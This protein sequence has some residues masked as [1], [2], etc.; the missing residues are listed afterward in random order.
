MFGVK[1]QGA[2][3]LHYSERAM[4]W[5]LLLSP[6]MDGPGNM[7]L[8]HALMAHARESGETVLRVY[9]WSSRVLSLGR[10]QRG[11]GVYDSAELARHGVT[12]VRRPTGGRALLHHREIT[13][14]VAM[15]VTADDSLPDLYRRI[16][17]L[18]MSTLTAYGVPASIASPRERTGSPGS[19][20]CF[21]QPAR[22]E[23]VADGRKLAGSAQWRDAGA[24]LQ[25]GSILI[26]DDQ[27]LIPGMMREPAQAPP[28]PATLRQYLAAP[29]S[30]ADFADAL[31]ERVRASEDAGATELTSS[32]IAA[33]P[34]ET[35]VTHYASAAWT[36]RR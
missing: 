32:D 36:W 12:V 14:S 15:P 2:E 13:Y 3:T 29:P 6:P 16:N 7:A 33:E 5:R 10:N 23:I 4:G 35:F 21:A 9:G 8:D 1:R 11:R 20:P 25:H 26:D 18:L 28:P 19:L 30:L 31:F 17:A 27:A 22:G 24:V 34:R